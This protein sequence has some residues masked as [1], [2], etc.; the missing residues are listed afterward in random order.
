MK[1]WGCIVFI[2]LANITIGAW[3]VGEILMWF[4]KSL[5]LW[6]DALIGLIVAE[7]SVPVAI[8]G[9]ILRVCGVF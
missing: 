5:P 6:A 9:W 3:S 4:G 1:N 7:V 8:V 2:I